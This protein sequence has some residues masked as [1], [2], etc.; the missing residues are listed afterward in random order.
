MPVNPQSLLE[1]LQ[2]RSGK[3]L[4]I[5]EIRQNVLSSSIQNRKPTRSRS[6]RKRQSSPPE[7]EEYLQSISEYGLISFNKDHPEIRVHDPFIVN[8]T[9]LASRSGNGFATG[10]FSK[11]IFIPLKKRFGAN[12]KDEVSVKLTNMKKDRFE[13]EVVQILKKCSDRFLGKVIEDRKSF[14]LIQ[15]IDLPDKA[16]CVLR[17]RNRPA[18]NSYVLVRLLKKTEKVFIQKKS[19]M[20]TRERKT[21]QNLYRVELIENE[22][23]SPEID[24]TLSDL[25]RVVIKYSLPAKYP[26]NAIPSKKEI[27]KKYSL[28]LEE[29]SRIDLTKIYACT[30]DGEDAKDFDDAISLEKEKGIIKLYVHIADVS[31]FISKGSVLDQEALKRGNSYYLKPNVLPM[32]P[33]ILSEE[34]CSL[35]P[36]TRR[37]ALTCEICFDQKGNILRYDFYQSI[38]YLSQRFTY[39][40]AEA[41]M[42]SKGSEIDQFWQFARLLRERRLKTGGIDLDIA[43]AEFSFDEKKR[44]T[45]INKK[46]RL[47]SH[48]LIEEFMLAANICAAQF[49]RKN[50]IPV[51]YRIHEPMDK[52][53]L[54]TLNYLLKLI[55]VQKQLKDI[56]Y[57]SLRNVIHSIQSKDHKSLFS[58]MLLRTFMQAEYNPVPKGH[59][60]LG[61][62]DYTHFTSPIRRYS[63]LIVHH[64]IK[65][66]LKR[67][68]L[69]YKKSELEEISK[70]I[71]Q[72]ERTAMEAERTIFKL[73]SIQFMSTIDQKIFFAN[74]I[75]F[76]TYGLFVLLES[77]P[78]EGFIPAHTFSNTGEVLNLDEFRIVLKK[79]QKTIMLGQRLKVQ[80]VKSDW[81]QMQLVF[82]IEEI[83]KK[84]RKRKKGRS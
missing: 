78:I 4:K 74:L 51:V 64:Q 15:L 1:Y 30:I 61:F 71:S 44:V 18:I 76:H 57:I 69:V 47:M 24:Q 77:P 28:G 2:V 72:D 38:I 42:D 29:R 80:F 3:N 84:A 65:S 27:E 32:L 53:K 81:D 33:N 10:K 56:E 70:K 50:K 79:F 36:K 7:L 55:G 5:K 59:W 67:S 13:G 82:K 39:E 35:K 62:K 52:K 75:G 21:L 20:S 37:L 66:F 8:A 31:F 45:G 49:C 63:D 46:S 48:Q 9:F 60:G 19:T 23:F 16:I 40:K 83:T 14:F 12:H 22:K 58:Y 68:D 73:L 34:Y 6:Q 26:E 43:E 11:D 17:S 25:Q 54:E 41:D